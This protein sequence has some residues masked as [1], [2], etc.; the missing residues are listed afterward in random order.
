MQ[1]EEVATFQLRLRDGKVRQGPVLGL[2]ERGLDLGLVGGKRAIA[3]AELLDF[4]GPAKLHVD[5][6]LALLRLH[7]GLELRARILGGD[8]DGDKIQIRGPVVGARTLPL[9]SVAEILVPREGRLPEARQLAVSKEDRDKERIFRR[10]PLGL[11]LIKGFLFRIG[12]KGVH[13]APWHD[14]DKPQV[15]PWSELAALVIPPPEA[16]AKPASGVEWVLLTRDGSLWRGKPTGMAKGSWLLE[17][18]IGSVGIPAESIVSGHVQSPGTRT[19][20][21]DLTPTKVVEHGLV[22]GESQWSDL[23]GFKNRRNSVGGPLQV[24]GSTWTQGIGAHSYSRLEFAVPEGRTRFLTQVG[25]DDS[26][27]STEPSGNAAFR[28][29]LDGKMVAEIPSLRGGQ[30]LRTF[31]AIQ[32]RAGQVLAL[33]LDFADHIYTGDRG[34]WVGAVFVP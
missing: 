18:A 27:L 21:S 7:S 29:L 26:A 25:I 34:N 8:E 9:D 15:Y 3:P 32:V 11:D 20:L 19:W 33:E 14:E 1:S 12:E 30:G 17:T 5:G 13:F 23:F 2:S 28:V 16:K 6:K 22:E 31:P 10:A 4:Q 24:D